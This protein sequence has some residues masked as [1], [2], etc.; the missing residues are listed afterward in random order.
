MNWRWEPGANELIVEIAQGEFDPVQ[1]NAVIL[2]RLLQRG[3]G[4][5]EILRGSTLETEYIKARGKP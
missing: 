5:L 1:V 2:P 4:I 3:I